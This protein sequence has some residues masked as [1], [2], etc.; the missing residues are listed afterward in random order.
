MAA[1]VEAESTTVDTAFLD[2]MTP[3][4][5]EKA[6]FTRIQLQ[7]QQTV[8]KLD[9]GAEVT[10]V[11]SETYKMLGKPTLHTPDKQLYGPSGHSLKVLGQ[12]KGTFA[13]NQITTQQM[14]YVIDQL[15]NNLLGLPTI[16]TLNL[17]PRIETTTQEEIPKL[18]PKVFQGLGNL[19]EEFTITLKPNA[20]PHALYTP[21]RIPLPLFPKVEEE[22]KRME[23]MGVISKVD[24]PTPWCAGMVVVP[25]K[26]GRVRICVDLKPLNENVLREVHPLPR[27]DETLARLSGAKVFSKLDA[28]SGFCQIP[29][30]KSSQL[31]TTFI[32]PSGRYKFN[33]LPFGISSVPEHFQKRM[34]EILRGLDGVVC[35]MD[36][37]L[38]FG[39]DQAEHDTRLTA[40]LKQIESAGATLNPDKCEFSCRRLKFLGHLIDGTGIQAD[41]EKTAAI[42]EMKAPSTVSELRRFMGMVNQLGKFSPNL[43]ELTQPLRELL[44]K[45]NAWLWGPTQERAFTQVKEELS[46]STTLTLYDPLA[47]TKLSADASSYGLGAVLLQKV[48]SD[49][50]PVAFASRSM[51]ETERQYAQVEKEALAITW[52]CEKFSMYILGK[53]FQVET[54]HKPLVP[55]LGS[56]HLD[57]LPPRVLRFRLRLARFDYSIVHI[58]GTHMYTADTLSRAPSSASGD[59]TL[60]ELAELAMTTCVAHLPAGPE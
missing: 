1:N 47:E 32:T 17:A 28:N 50:K 42:R 54:D 9:T 8:F 53:R 7:G 59:P 34:S 60:E 52:A 45:H 24:E 33:K 6:W 40:V 19:G 55:L 25:K 36:D 21:R 41:P 38:V 35:Q 57:S 14:V 2:N 20:T 30:A 15:K 18:F 5:Q 58:P 13:H 27:V 29:L 43:A 39:R 10:A 16:T 44:S 11:N 3:A 23:S 37:V 48:D 31:L 56:K 26:N 22:L 4:G 51:T 46:K 49:W 12:F